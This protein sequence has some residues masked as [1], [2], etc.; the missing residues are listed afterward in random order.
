MFLLILEREV[1]GER[2]RER[3]GGREEG[4]ERERERETSTGFLPYTL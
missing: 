2:D 3:E 1:V 4:R